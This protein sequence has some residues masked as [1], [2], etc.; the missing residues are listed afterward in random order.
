MFFFPDPS[1]FVLVEFHFFHLNSIFPFLVGA[2]ILLGPGLRLLFVLL[3]FC[4]PFFPTPN[5]SY[6]RFF[7]IYIYSLYYAYLSI[8]MLFLFLNAFGAISK[9]LYISLFFLFVMK[10]RVVQHGPSTLIVSLPS[11]W[12]KRNNVKKGDEVSVV[13]EGSSLI[14]SSDSLPE[15]KSLTV[16]LKG[17]D[18]TSFILALRGFYRSGFDS[19]KVFFDQSMPYFRRGKD[20]FSAHALHHEVNLMVGS[21]VVNE[22]TNSAEINDLVSEK[23]ESL[24]VVIRRV[25]FLLSDAADTFLE[26]INDPEELLI[27]EH[28]HDTL[29]RFVSYALRIINKKSFSSGDHYLFSILLFI[30][31]L[32][33]FIKYSAREIR[34][35]SLSLSPEVV[36]FMTDVIGSVK[37]FEK[38]FFK[39]SLSK[40]SELESRRAKLKKSLFDSY[41]KFS[42]SELLI[43]VWFESILELLLTMSEA[44]M[45][46][47][48]SKNNL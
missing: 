16:D 44:V 27:I 20:I 23:G 26:N 31:K 46:I 15:P 32:M 36:S 7:V 1:V 14:I 25:F 34:A 5:N 35:R 12:V 30:D 33:D 29:T 38:L 43:L 42:S 19:I 11:R 10:R 4:I 45:A 8:Y 22:S 39:F 48:A 24:E 21:E 41:S 47:N 28:K 9:H 2:S 3:L 6:E 18:R 40:V 37:L 17:I 13:D